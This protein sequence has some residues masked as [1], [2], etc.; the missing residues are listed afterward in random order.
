MLLI[1]E[2]GVSL[3]RMLFSLANILKPFLI[4]DIRNM[5]VYVSTKRSQ[6]ICRF[7]TRHWVNFEL[8][9]WNERFFQ[10]KQQIFFLQFSNKFLYI[11]WVAGDLG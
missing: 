7:I 10:I 1:L 3:L 5:F 9:N 11:P 2:Y 8:P 6:T 4:L